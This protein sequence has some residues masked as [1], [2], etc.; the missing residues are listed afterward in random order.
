MLTLWVPY[1]PNQQNYKVT[2]SLTLE[3]FYTVD[4]MTHRITIRNISIDP[5][6]SLN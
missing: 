3:N 5:Y 6:M 1:N 4:L 2:T